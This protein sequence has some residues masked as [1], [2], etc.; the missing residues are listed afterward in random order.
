VEEIRRQDLDATEVLFKK[1]TGVP[2]EEVDKKRVDYQVAVV[3]HQMAEEQLL[4]RRIVAPF[5][6]TISDLALDEGEACEAYQPLVRLVDTQ[7]CYFVSNIEAKAGALL[8]L[9]QTV[10]VEIE[11]GLSP[12]RLEAKI[13][14]LAPVV[15]PSSGLL[16]IKAV[17]DNSEA[18][19]RP[20][21]A[22]R[23]YFQA[24][25]N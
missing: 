23:V 16:K 25:A 5:S 22:G 2:K 3:E 4:R 17:F 6:G 21:L 8:K 1:T 10:T 18:Q 11:T 20:G 7:R 19:I 13:V 14:Y 12:V 15:D 24:Y 9:D